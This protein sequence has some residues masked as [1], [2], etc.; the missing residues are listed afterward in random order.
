MGEVFEAFLFGIVFL[1]VKGLFFLLALFTAIF[2]L[3]SLLYAFWIAI[4]SVLGL[5]Y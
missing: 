2:T 3:G 4:A 1:I 5:P